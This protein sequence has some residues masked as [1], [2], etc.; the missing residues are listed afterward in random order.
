MVPYQIE[1]GYFKWEI[2]YKHR[3]VEKIMQ[4]WADNKEEAIE[5]A[6]LELI[7]EDK[8]TDCIILNVRKVDIFMEFLNE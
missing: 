6:V 8:A 5:K 3:G 4:V 7:K 1:T 2:K